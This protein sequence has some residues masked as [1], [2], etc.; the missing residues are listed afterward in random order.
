MKRIG[1]DFSEDFL[2]ARRQTPRFDPPQALVIGNP[3][4]SKSM[5]DQLGTIVLLF[6]SPIG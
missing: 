5:Q 3:V 4:R 2:D 1:L 6:S